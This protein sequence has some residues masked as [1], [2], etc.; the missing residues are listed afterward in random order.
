[1]KKYLLTIVVCLFTTVF[2]FRFEKA[3]AISLFQKSTS[4]PVLFTGGNVWDNNRVAHPSVLLTSNL[5]MWY[6]GHNNTYWSTGLASSSDGIIW[7]K[8]ISNPV[9][10]WNLSITEPKNFNT[11]SVLIDGDMLKIW[12]TSTPDDLS[13]FRIGY[14]EY[15]QLLGWQKISFDVLMIP[16]GS[17]GRNATH[18]FVLRN[19]SG[20]HLWFSSFDDGGIWKIGYSHSDNGISWTMGTHNPIIIGTGDTSGEGSHTGGPSVL[21]DES[22]GIY[23]MW[24]SSNFAS[25]QLSFINY[26]E[27][28]FPDTGW[29]KP[30]DKNPVLT[31]GQ[32]GLF[33]DIAIGD[34]SVVKIGDTHLL[35]YTA[36][37]NVD[38][39]SKIRI[40]L[41]T[42]GP[43]VFPTLTPTPTETPVPTETPTPTETPIPTNTPEPTP[44]LVPVTKIVLVPGLAGSLSFDQIFN[45]T[46]D[47]NANWSSWPL[48]DLEYQPFIQTIQR[49]GYTPLVF[50]YDWRRDPRESAAKLK[51]FIDSQTAVGEKVYL[52]GHSLG[53]LVAR[54]Y[55]EQEQGLAKVEKYVSVASPH[56]GTALAYYAWSGG[57][58]VGD[59]L[60]RTAA[61]FIQSAC[62]HHGIANPR[63]IVQTYFPST[64]SL[65]PTFDY[66]RDKRANI[67]K[68]TSSLAAQN[69]WLPNTL[70]FPPFYGIPTGSIAGNGNNTIREILTKPP[71][72]ADIFLGK[73]LDGKPMAKVST[74][75][76]D[77][78]VLGMSSLLTDSFQS[79]LDEN[80][81]SIMRTTI[82]IQTIF[83]NLGIPSPLSALAL[84]VSP[85]EQTPSSAIILLSDADAITINKPNGK[86]IVSREGTLLLSDPS[87]ENFSLDIDPKTQLTN[88]LVI[89][90]LNND[91]TLSHRYTFTNK[92]RKH[93]TLRFS[94][95][96]PVGDILK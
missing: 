58:I 83:S 71:S 76:G 89:Q 81:L 39:E 46:N 79:T 90:V 65:L 52:V 16:S 53:G 5:Q 12:F 75:A 68:P 95:R 42:D 50:Y 22:T 77:G 47:P 40:G 63:H 64:Q 2:F 26:A 23:K 34:P 73:W 61:A 51:L 9:L 37:G 55:I 7:S 15:D 28:A 93:K 30:A 78:T 33:D 87:E 56:Q 1:M 31:K 43:I 13:N 4:N 48:S 24:Y 35:Y 20:Y 70:F 17:W 49:T 54:A 69:N 91:V 57:E 85:G 44:T 84:S 66:L 60:W 74:S 6:A 62:V 14:A 27:S 82:S 59:F 36:W 96:T 94:R 8:S 32:P 29:T 11:P 38:G 10:A 67:L 45:C 86:K 19:N 41:A 88:L 18:P 21:Y 25:P 3:L 72:G 80:H 92:T